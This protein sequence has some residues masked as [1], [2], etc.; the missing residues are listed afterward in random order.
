MKDMKLRLLAISASALCGTFVCA[1]QGYEG[2]RDFEYVKATTPVLNLSNPAALAG[3]DGKISQ[4]AVR[5]DKA[6]GG[7]ASLTQSKDSYEVAAGTESFYRIS[8]KIAFY[9]N[10]DWSYFNGKKT[11]SYSLKGAMSYSFNDRWAAGLTV[12]FD[13]RDQTKVKDPRFLNYWTDLSFNAGVSFRP[14]SSVLLGASAF[15]RNTL[16]TV[17]G[18]IYGKT[19][20]SYFF[21]VD[22]G[23]YFGTV[24]ELVGT[25][26]E[27]SP[28]D[29]RPMNNNLF[30]G[31]IQMAVGDQ[32]FG[33]V[34][35][36]ARDGYYGRKSSSG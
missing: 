9:G 4:A 20:Q 1:A 27:L 12:K 35:F 31:A 25:R 32:Y 13:G 26:A 34:T 17:Q 24:A 10:I 14:S 2:L 5:F 6:N 7:L 21:L 11:E 3:W 19:D 22:R 33:E 23:N 18:G 28:S 8:D 29:K 30:G 16:E 36:T 15:Y